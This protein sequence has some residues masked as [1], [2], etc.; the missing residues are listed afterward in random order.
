MKINDYDFH[1]KLSRLH[2]WCKPRVKCSL[3]QAGV[4][5]YNYLARLPYPYRKT[6][7]DYCH[8]R[9]YFQFID[10]TLVSK[11]GVS[12][13]NDITCIE[14]FTYALGLIN[15]LLAEFMLDPDNLVEI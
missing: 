12:T 6:D 2:T 8:E 1:K 15:E 14:A 3:N 4:D 7:I 9:I 10:G 13:L 11:W 5:K